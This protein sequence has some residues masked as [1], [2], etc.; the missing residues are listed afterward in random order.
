MH[1]YNAAHT[2][3]APAIMFMVLWL[4]GQEL[5]EEMTIIWVAHIAADRLLGFGLKYQAD[6][7]QTHLSG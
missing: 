3:L 2:Y 6:T 5:V 4:S 7:K 1:C